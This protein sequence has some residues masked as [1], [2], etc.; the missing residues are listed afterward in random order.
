[1]QEA[2][3]I[4]IVAYAAIAVLL[5]YAPKA[6]TRGLRRSLAKAMARLGL[7][8]VAAVLEKGSAQSDCAD[9]CGTCGGCGPRTSKQAGRTVI[10]I[11]ALKRSGTD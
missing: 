1:M 8:R 2:I 6:L 3:V 7:R 10:S 4:L 5:R 9:G 11:D